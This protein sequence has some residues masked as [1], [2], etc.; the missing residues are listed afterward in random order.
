M[1]ISQVSSLIGAY[2]VICRML[3]AVLDQPERIAYIRCQNVQVLRLNYLKIR[4]ILL[5]LHL[6][7]LL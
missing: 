6:S 4:A 5:R 3:R 2:W 7:G 1:F